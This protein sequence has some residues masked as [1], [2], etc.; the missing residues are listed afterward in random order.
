MKRPT[1][2][3][4]RR[5]ARQWDET[6]PLLE[7][8]HRQALRNKP[9]D[10]REVDALLSLVDLSKQPPRT[11]SGLVEQQRRFMEIRARWIQES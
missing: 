10:W 9:Y 3:D 7:R 8:L 11:T 5:L 1:P 2:D 6:G 4:E